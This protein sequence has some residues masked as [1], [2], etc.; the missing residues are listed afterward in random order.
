MILQVMILINTAGNDTY[1]LIASILIEVWFR[2][3]MHIVWFWTLT[4]QL[5][6][7]ICKAKYDVLMIYYLKDLEYL[8]FLVEL[9]AVI[10]LSRAV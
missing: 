2:W 1:N 9:L 8:F 6:S 7:L 3:H 5:V 10:I 4:R